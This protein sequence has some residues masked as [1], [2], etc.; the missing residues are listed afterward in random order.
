MAARATAPDRGDIVWLEFELQRGH[1]QA[2]RRPAL[3]LSPAAYN[4]RSGL[5]V[6]CAISSR[7]KGYPFEVRIPPGC[8]IQGVVLADQ[9]RTIDWRAR[10]AKVASQLPAPAIADV[11]AKLA[12]LL[13]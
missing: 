3:V 7:V 2:G 12:T 8:P 9:L 13:Q 10:R 1:D 6:C 11:L 5:A 4:Q